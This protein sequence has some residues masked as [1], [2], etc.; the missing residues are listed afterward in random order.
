M[1]DEEKPSVE[2]P[3]APGRKPTTRFDYYAW[4]MI[5]AAT[6][7][8]ILAIEYSYATFKYWGTFKAMLY[9]LDMASWFT[10]GIILFYEAFRRLRR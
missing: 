6:I 8:M 4:F 7:S 9:A 2:E 5:L 1:L 3:V 10:P